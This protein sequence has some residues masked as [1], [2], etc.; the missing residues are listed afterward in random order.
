MPAKSK[1]GGDNGKPVRR[2]GRKAKEKTFGSDFE[3]DDPPKKKA[4]KDP[5]P[6]PLPQSPPQPVSDPKPGTSADPDPG[7]PEKLK[8]ASDPKHWCRPVLPTNHSKRSC[9]FV[10]E[11]SSAEAPLVS[12]YC[13][14]DITCP[15]V[16]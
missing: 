3:M 8:W 13:E 16:F 2:S 9:I 7:S 4:R 15:N 6:E 14:R 11:P 5:E 10:L 1:G 12:I